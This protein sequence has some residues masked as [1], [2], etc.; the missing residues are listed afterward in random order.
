MRPSR[1]ATGRT[2]GYLSEESTFAGYP[3]PK[4]EQDNRTPEQHLAFK[5]RF[6][7]NNVSDLNVMAKLAGYP[8]P[9]ANERGPESRESKDTRDSGGI[10]LQS[11]VMLAGHPTPR[12]EDSESTGPH[13]GA[14]DTLTSSAAMISGPASPC[15]PTETARRGALN[16][17]LSA[18]LM[19]LP[20]PVRLCG[21][22]AWMNRKRAKSSARSRSR[23]TSQG[24]GCS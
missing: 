13:R 19:G 3:S 16:P 10:D 14:A 4:A 7:S 15:S 5:N 12:A 9:N 2:T 20:W 11:V 8:T 24:G 6:G 21:L 18:W 22:L 23:E 17:N 1:A